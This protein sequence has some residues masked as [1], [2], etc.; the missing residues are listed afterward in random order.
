MVKMNARKNYDL[1]VQAANH[2]T[3][4]GQSDNYIPLRRYLRLVMQCLCTLNC[5]V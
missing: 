5:I 4:I 3:S 1:C 2:I